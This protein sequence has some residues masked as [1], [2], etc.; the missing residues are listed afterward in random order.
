MKKKQQQKTVEGINIRSDN[1]EQT[2]IWKT[3]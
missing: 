1:T 3:W 2:A